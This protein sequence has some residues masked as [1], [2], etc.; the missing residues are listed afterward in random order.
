MGY[1][2]QSEDSSVAAER[3]LFETYERM[4]PAEKVERVRSLC[5]QANQLALAGLRSR[6][7]GDSEEALR[8]RLA[9]I[10][11]GDEV[12]EKVLSGRDG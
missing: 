2:P 11:L 1:R 3:V 10:R 7:P 8:F 4:T 9:A 6:H 5:R 12:A